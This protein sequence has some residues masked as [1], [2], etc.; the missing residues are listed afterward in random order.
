MLFSLIVSFTVCITK[1][2]EGDR[3]LNSLS[4]QEQR[5]SELKRIKKAYA[6]EVSFVFL[7]RP[8]VQSMTTDLQYSQWL[9]RVYTETGQVL[10]RVKWKNYSQLSYKYFAYS[11]NWWDGEQTNRL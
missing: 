10:L 7:Y 5:K 6:L 8:T 4:V 3:S 9:L 2:V 11:S 1:V